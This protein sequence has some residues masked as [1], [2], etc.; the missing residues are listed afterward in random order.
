MRMVTECAY[1]T[2]QE[3]PREAAYLRKRWAQICFIS[4][5]RCGT[6]SDEADTGDFG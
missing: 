6:E 5:D 2:A 1:Q 3:G 4:G